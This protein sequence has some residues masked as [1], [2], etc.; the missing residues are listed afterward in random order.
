MRGEIQRALE[1]GI[2][3]DGLVGVDRYLSNTL[4]KFDEVDRITVAT[5]EG[6]PVAIAERKDRASIFQ[7]G[8]LGE[9]FDRS[10]PGSCAWR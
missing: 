1:L 6:K 10:A 9:V 5:A 7:S 4:N 2:P 8:A 3:I